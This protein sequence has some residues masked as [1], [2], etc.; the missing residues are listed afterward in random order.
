MDGVSAAGDEPF[1]WES[2]VSRVLHPI[3][4][5][6]IEAMLWIGLPLA[7][8]D[9]SPI[10]GG[11]Y[12]DSHIAYHAR[13]LANRGVLELVNEEAVRGTTKHYYVLAPESRWL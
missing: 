9:I 3:Q 8:S 1:P 11:E 2:L 10:F 5:A 7:P 13:A 6:V 4:V 12:S